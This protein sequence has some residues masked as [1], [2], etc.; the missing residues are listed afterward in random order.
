MVEVTLAPNEFYYASTIGVMRQIKNLQNRRRDRYGAQKEDGWRMHIEGACGECAFAKW[1]GMFWSGSLENLRAADVGA[2][3]VRTRSRPY[4]DLIVHPNEADD[5]RFVLVLGTAP[6][7]KLAGYMYG[8]DA[9]DQRYWSDPAGGR[10]AFFV[11]Q[12][13][14]QPIEELKMEFEL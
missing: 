5:A 13:E 9:K 2:Y 11:P 14:L 6:H 4:Y 3:E 7:F 8:R 10:P 12:K 1:M